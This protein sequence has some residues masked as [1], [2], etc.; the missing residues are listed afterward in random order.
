MAGILYM[1]GDESLA[2]WLGLMEMN[3]GRC[4]FEDQ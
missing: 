4:Y 3:G 2:C 1:V